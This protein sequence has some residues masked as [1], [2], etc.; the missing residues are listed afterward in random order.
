MQLFK[1]VKK[2]KI[3]LRHLMFYHTLDNSQPEDQTD[4][5]QKNEGTEKDNTTSIFSTAGT[6]IIDNSSKTS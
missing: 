6:N 1:I 2:C 5:N 4:I 3:I